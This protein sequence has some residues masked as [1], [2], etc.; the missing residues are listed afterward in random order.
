MRAYRLPDETIFEI[1]RLAEEWQ[2]T[3][4]EVLERVIASRQTAI[5]TG[6]PWK[7]VNRHVELKVDYDDI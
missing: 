3:Q 2:C 7:A 1:E 5:K 6:D 4:A